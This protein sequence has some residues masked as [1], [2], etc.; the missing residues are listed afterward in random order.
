LANNQTKRSVIAKAPMADGGMDSNE[1][2]QD[3]KSQALEKIFK[4]APHLREII[5][6]L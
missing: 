6:N 3:L 2:Y 5:N 4:S 1:T